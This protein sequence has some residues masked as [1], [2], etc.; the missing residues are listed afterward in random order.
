M[1][2]DKNEVYKV[3]KNMTLE[4]FASIFNT[5]N[6]IEAVENVKKEDNK[7]LYTINELIEK[8]PF[9]T[10]YNINK[11]IQSDGLPYCL[12]GNKRMFSKEEID[13]WLEKETSSKKEKRRYNI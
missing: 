6:K 13:R 2:D 12:I 7:V 5:T 3:L 8:Y 1:L 4:E 11:A 9:F 10:R